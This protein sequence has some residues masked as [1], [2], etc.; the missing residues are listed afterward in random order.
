MKRTQWGY[1]LH[2]VDD[3]AFSTVRSG[4]EKTPVSWTLGTTQRATSKSAASAAAPPRPWG[5]RSATSSSSA[6]R[7]SSASTAA[8]STTPAGDAASRVHTRDPFGDHVADRY[9][10]DE[11]R[12]HRSEEAAGSQCERAGQPVMGAFVA[13]GL[14]RDEG[15]GSRVGG[16]LV[17]NSSTTFL[18]HRGARI[19]PGNGTCSG[20]GA[21]RRE[22]RF[23]PSPGGGRRQDDSIHGDRRPFADLCQ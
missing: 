18:D 1:Q 13:I 19:R 6:S 8:A 20:A 2:V 12:R 3:R 23:N 14:Q 17:I 15:R 5:R 10:R 22:H 11:G 7:T 16:A 4:A 9:I 21:T